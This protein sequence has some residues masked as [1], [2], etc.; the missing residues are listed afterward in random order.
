[1]TYEIKSQ[2]DNAV[3]QVCTAF[4]KSWIDSVSYTH[5]H[6]HIYIYIYIERE[7]ERERE[8]E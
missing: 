7:R 2:V 8:S 4:W 1:M 3:G 5:T 6:T